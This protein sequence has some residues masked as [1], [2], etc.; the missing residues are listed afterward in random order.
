MK[1]IVIV[2]IA[3]QNTTL[4]QNV[5]LIKTTRSSHNEQHNN[6]N[7][8]SLVHGLLHTRRILNNKR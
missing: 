8:I 3:M 7:I 6:N 5:G 1:W 4:L 2:M